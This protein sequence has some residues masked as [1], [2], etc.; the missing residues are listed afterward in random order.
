NI[1][2]QYRD[3][4]PEI[5]QMQRP[6]HRAIELLIEQNILSEDG[7]MLGLRAP[8]QR[9]KQLIET[10]PYFKD[11]V[12]GEFSAKKFREII[13]KR[14][15]ISENDFIRTIENDII[16]E[17]IFKNMSSDIYIP[18]DVLKI[19][20]EYNMEKRDIDYIV[21]DE[22]SLG[23]LP[24]F[25]MSLEEQKDYFT[26]HKNHSA[27]RRPELRDVAF[28]TFTPD[29]LKEL[30]AIDDAKVKARYEANPSRF[31]T[32]EKRKILQ[33]LFDTKD[34]ADEA[35]KTLENEENFLAAAIDLG[36]ELENID[37]G[38]ISPDD[39][40]PSEI[41]ALKENKYTNVLE[42]DFGYV[43]YYVEEI[44]PSETIAFKDVKKNLKQNMLLKAFR[45][46]TDDNLDLIE[47]DLAGGATLEEMAQK[48]KV[49][50]AKY[51]NITSS[52]FIYGQ[53]NRVIENNDLLNMLFTS[54]LED[55]VMLTEIENGFI[56]GHPTDIQAARPKSF[57]EAQADLETF[58]KSR[59]IDDKLAQLYLEITSKKAAKKLSLTDISASYGLKKSSE[60]L[61]RYDGSAALDRV[62]VQELFAEPLGTLSLSSAPSLRQKSF[63]IAEVQN[64]SVPELSE[65]QL[66]DIRNGLQSTLQRDIY[67]HMIKDA[68]DNVGVERNYDSYNRFIVGEG[69]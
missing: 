29:T 22:N 50:L 51:Q 40:F 45:D 59:L 53:N 36:F 2:Q 52:G 68:G 25:N 4:P 15:R 47:D 48:Y 58:Y 9:I 6:S 35:T 19:H 37:L 30:L 63:T 39:G 26:K 41:F 33:L 3:L 27:F 28:L 11:D 42:N 46:F 7:R 8:D 31:Q 24:A 44:S 5:A 13:K 21:F 54:A 18:D 57:E 64:V 23:Q 32:P 38:F 1:M 60:T 20:A 16:R 17:M 34:K 67:N 10:I 56:Y 65:N 61:G 66:E 55:D 49:P 62:L 12:T 14:F 43:I 69:L